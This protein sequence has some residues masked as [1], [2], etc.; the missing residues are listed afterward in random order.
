MHLITALN[1]KTFK[2]HFNMRLQF[3]MKLY[4]MLLNIVAFSLAAL[5]INNFKA[6]QA[7]VSLLDKF[8]TISHE[9]MKSDMLCAIY[10][11][12]QSRLNGEF[13]NAYTFSDNKCSVG[14]I[15]PINL[16]GCGKP[17]DVNENMLYFCETCEQPTT[18]ARTTTEIP[19][20]SRSST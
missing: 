13:I 18:T 1:A 8:T 11:N 4:F 17:N 5:T 20:Q 12:K 3:N 2:S 19:S 7:D 15:D 16:D 9:T 14:Y 10:F 6:Y